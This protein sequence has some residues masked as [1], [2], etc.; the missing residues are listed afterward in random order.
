MGIRVLAS[1]LV[2]VAAASPAYGN[3]RAFDLRHSSL[4]VHVHKQ[5]LF[6]FLADDH[7]IDA[8]IASGAYDGDAKTVELTVDATKMRVLDPRLAATQRDAV[9]TNMTGPVLNVADN[10]TI[11]F[12]STKIDDA[13]PSRWTV[14]GNL[15]LHGQTHPVTVALQKKDATHF[16]GSATVRQTAFGITPIR[17]AGGA[18]SVKDDVELTFEIALEP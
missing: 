4:T 18:V 5:G 6:S 1:I 16:S 12:R 3:P 9:Q 17:I 13:N 14:D 8:P 10:P 2:A 11:V 15:T 7:V